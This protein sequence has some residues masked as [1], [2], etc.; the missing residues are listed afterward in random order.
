MNTEKRKAKTKKLL[1]AG[2]LWL[3][4]AYVLFMPMGT[5]PGLPTWAY[6]ALDVGGTIVTLLFAVEYCA[7]IWVAERKRDYVLSFWG[8]LDFVA[9]WPA[10]MALIFPVPGVEEL[11]GLRLLRLFQVAKSVRYNRAA[12]R[13]AEAI[14]DSKEE[15]VMFAAATGILLYLASVGIYYFEH[16]AQPDVFKSVFHA[17]WWAVV[18]LTAVGYGDVYPITTGGRIFTCFV[19]LIGLAVVATPAGII[20]RALSKANAQEGGWSD[21][22]GRW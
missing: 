3:I 19:V 7:R 12:A 13:F 11:R 17:L 10:V 15:M 5:L 16:Q 6:S 20:A 8:I 14:R 2:A 21:R 9:I 4:G 18:T 22:R 1:E